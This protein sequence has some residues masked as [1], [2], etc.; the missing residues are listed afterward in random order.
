MVKFETKN[1]FLNLNAYLNERLI[2]S[3]AIHLDMIFGFY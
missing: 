3:D 1:D 2:K